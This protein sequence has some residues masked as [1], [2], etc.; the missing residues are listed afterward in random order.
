MS[1]S[2]QDQS[3]LQVGKDLLALLKNNAPLHDAIITVGRGSIKAKDGSNFRNF[4]AHS[5]ILQARC[6]Y[7]KAYFS[8][9][10]S[11][12]KDENGIYQIDLSGMGI[13][14]EAFDHVLSYIYSGF[15]EFHTLNLPLISYLHIVQAAD[16]LNIELLLDYT[17]QSI[18]VP[19]LIKN[20]FLE[21]L[22]EIRDIPGCIDLATTCRVYLFRNPKVIFTCPMMTLE[23]LS[24]LL[25]EPIL[26]LNEVAI[27]DG[28]LN[29][30]FRNN[31]RLKSS[32]SD[33]NPSSLRETMKPLMPL[34]DFYMISSDNFMRKVSKFKA[35]F[36]GETY[37]QLL[38]YHSKHINWRQSVPLKPLRINSRILGEQAILFLAN[39]I[40]SKSSFPIRYTSIDE[41]PYEFHFLLRSQENDGFHSL[42]HNP[43]FPILILILCEQ[44]YV[45]GR[46]TPVSVDT[47]GDF[48][49]FD[50]QFETTTEDFSISNR[51]TSEVKQ[52][53][54]I[55]LLNWL[56][57]SSSEVL[58]YLKRKLWNH[59][60][61]DMF[62]I[63]SIIPKSVKR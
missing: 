47:S 6:D 43:R 19:S 53:D 18:S 34:I 5:L 44:R 51:L 2:I 16:A 50:F 33:E 29:W 21:I 60:R 25:Q 40:K 55:N 12:H 59:L 37:D 58:A 32:W 3:L 11:K 62:E 14:P 8:S 46:F 20:R 42:K 52:A 57:L 13:D 48:K 10:W 45:K 15:I 36:D 31:E 9:Y 17:K 23:F 41:I 35:L 56:E 27:W 39:S 30:A 28:C 7:F 1:K 61:I 38:R 49:D 63:F 54:R 22:L 24:E 4:K 26:G